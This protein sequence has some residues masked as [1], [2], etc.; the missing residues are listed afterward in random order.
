VSRLILASGSPRRIKLLQDEKFEIEAVPADVQELSCD[1]LTPT[2]LTLFNAFQKAAAV[3]IRYPDAV[4][5]GADTLV[6]LGSEVFGKP[7]DL[8]EARRMLEKLVGKTHAVITG[9]ALIQM[10]VGQ[11]ITRAVQTTVKI[12]PLTAPEIEAYLEIAEPLDKAGAYAAQKSPDLIIE[13]INGSFTNVVGL[14]MELV[15]GLLTSAGIHPSRRGFP[16][17]PVANGHAKTDSH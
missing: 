5:L 12:R 9:V 1:F 7:R 2:E 16:A 17:K 14:P 3:A 4:V 6:A 11:V 15:R 8:V 10:A 13:R